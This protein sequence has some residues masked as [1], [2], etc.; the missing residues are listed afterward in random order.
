M[1]WNE[2]RSP[3]LLSDGELGRKP[4]LSSA[5]VWAR[6][7]GWEQDVTVRSV[8]FFGFLPGGLEN[9]RSALG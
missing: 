6:S 3:R 4:R 7:V 8:H 9:R 5:G 2:S 1:F